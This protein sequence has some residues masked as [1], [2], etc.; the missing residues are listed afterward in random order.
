[1]NP[2]RVTHIAQARAL[3]RVKQREPIVVDECAGSG[4][5]TMA[6]GRRGRD[7]SMID[8]LDRH[9]R[10]ASESFNPGDRLHL[11]ACAVE[12]AARGRSINAVA[13]LK[14]IPPNHEFGPL[15]T[16]GLKKMLR[17]AAGALETVAK[18][19]RIKGADIEGQAVK[20]VAIG[21]RLGIASMLQYCNLAWSEMERE[22]LSAKTRGEKAQRWLEKYDAEY[23]AAL[24]KMGPKKAAKKARS[25]ILPDYRFARKDGTITDASLKTQ[26]CRWRKLVAEKPGDTQG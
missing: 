15:D 12:A 17:D 21:Y 1:M 5:F 23:A 25:V 8:N 3:A 4:E 14:D 6:D 19:W 11:V 10:Y 26:L 22:E 13:E 9:L 16:P 24:K 20:L 7:E 18:T 2:V